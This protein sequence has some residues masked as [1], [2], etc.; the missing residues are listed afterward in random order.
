MQDYE[1]VL[2]MYT[3]EG[4]PQNKDSQSQYPR[5]SFQ[6]FYNGFAA[7]IR[8]PFIYVFKFEQELVQV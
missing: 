6:E 5:L 1:Q 8:V 7:K 3:K 4:T 2:H